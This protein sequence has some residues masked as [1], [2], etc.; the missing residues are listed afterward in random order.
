MM[1]E[2]ADQ[3]IEANFAKWEAYASSRQFAS[4]PASRQ[5]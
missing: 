2:M 5:A 1:R 3:L 4:D